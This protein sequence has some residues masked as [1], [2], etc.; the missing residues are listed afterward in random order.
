MDRKITIRIG[1][2]EYILKASSEESEE[3]IRLAAETVN[4]KLSQFQAA[5]PGKEAVDLMSFI[6]LN[7]CISNI[8]LQRKLE[9]LQGKIASL[10]ADTGAYLKNIEGK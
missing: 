6:A 7:V 5:Y 1:E 9:D 8:S 2:K 10:D 3:Y 4:G